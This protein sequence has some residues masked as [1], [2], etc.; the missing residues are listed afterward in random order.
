MIL[1]DV[2]E[3]LVNI[4]KDLKKAVIEHNQFLKELGLDLLPES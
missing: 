2:N 3:T 1:K 4:D